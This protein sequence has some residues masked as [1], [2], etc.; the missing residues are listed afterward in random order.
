MMIPPSPLDLENGPQRADLVGCTPPAESSD[1]QPADSCSGCLPSYTSEGLLKQ[2]GRL[3]GLLL[4]P[5]QVR[6]GVSCSWP[7]CLP[8]P[9]NPSSC[10]ASPHHAVE[11]WTLLVT[12]RSL[13]CCPAGPARLPGL[14][15]RLDIVS[16]AVPGDLEPA[17]RGAYLVCHQRTPP[18]PSDIYPRG[19][20]GC[21]SQIRSAG[22]A[23]HTRIQ[24]RASS[25]HNNCTL[26]LLHEAIGQ[27]IEAHSWPD[28]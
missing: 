25:L 12:L 22:P 8:A 19:H 17:S 24:E 27:Q 20:W 7:P 10:L 15:A 18:K 6:L 26:P 9:S 16:G 21:P 23:D 3:P 28:S 11:L 5:V 13:L 14:P 1:G 4:L 2:A